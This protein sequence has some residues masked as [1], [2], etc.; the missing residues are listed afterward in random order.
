MPLRSDHPAE[1][2]VIVED[3][4]DEVHAVLELDFQWF[5]DGNV[6]IIHNTKLISKDEDDDSED[7]HAGT[8]TLPPEPARQSSS[9]LPATNSGRTGPT[10]NSASRTDPRSLE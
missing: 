9:T 7:T 10:G 4:G 6:E 1:H 2:I 5:L 3:D 8:V